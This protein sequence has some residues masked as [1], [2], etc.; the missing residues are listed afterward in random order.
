MTERRRYGRQAVEISN[1]DRIFFPDAGITKGDLIDYYERVADIMLPHVGGR[2]VMM[3]RF[4]D[5]LG[6]EG[7]YQKEV[8]DYFPDWIRTVEVKKEGGRLTQLVIENAATLVYLANQACIDPHVWLSR[9]DRPDH[10]DRM[11]FDLDPAGSDFSAVRSAARAFG[12]ILRDLR[13][14]PFVMTTGSR[15]L[16]VAVP[17][18]RRA[19]FDTV[20]AF[21]REVAEVV[22]SRDPE[23]LT[24]EQRKNKRRGR[25]FVDIQRNAYA[26]TAVAPYAVRPQPGAPVATPLE[27]EELGDRTLRSQ[28]Y[29]LKNLFRRLER[30]GDPWKHIARHASSLREAQRRLKDVVADAEPRARAR[31][32]GG[33]R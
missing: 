6:G 5:G 2:A 8:P 28:R 33:S 17:L 9:V 13:L 14:E 25:L 21:A 31:R 30:D 24:T 15:G 18:D 29:T 26:Q 7:F 10:P 20:R 16:H 3:R 12:E 11:I 4:P 22:V 32:R 19:D 23:R 27:W 1:P